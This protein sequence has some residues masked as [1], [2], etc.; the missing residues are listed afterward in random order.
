[1]SIILYLVLINLVS[2]IMSMPNVFFAFELQATHRG[3]L[4][5]GNKQSKSKLIAL[6]LANGELVV[7]VYWLVDVNDCVATS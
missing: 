5:N 1:M 2:G 7:D 4:M 3:L 6:T